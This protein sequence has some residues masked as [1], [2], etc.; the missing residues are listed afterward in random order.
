VSIF[1]SARVERGTFAYEETKRAAK[2][3]AEMGC[4]I[5]TGGGLVAAPLGAPPAGDWT[6]RLLSDAETFLVSLIRTGDALE[7]QHAAGAAV[8]G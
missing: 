1:G 6:E 3:L 4:G 2:A 7:R 5:V 8:S